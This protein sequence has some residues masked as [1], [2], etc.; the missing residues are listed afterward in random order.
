MARTCSANPPIAQMVGNPKGAVSK[1]GNPDQSKESVLWKNRIAV[2]DFVVPVNQTTPTKVIDSASL[3]DRLETWATPFSSPQKQLDTQPKKEAID[4]SAHLAKLIQQHSKTKDPQM[5]TTSKEPTT[6]KLVEM[7]HTFEPSSSAPRRAPTAQMVPL[8]PNTAVTTA[9]A[10]PVTT[11]TSKSS[12]FGPRPSSMTLSNSKAFFP[13]TASPSLLVAPIIPS[14]STA[15]LKKSAIEKCSPKKPKITMTPAPAIA[16]SASHVQNTKLLSRAKNHTNG[17]KK[18]QRIRTSSPPKSASALESVSEEKRG[19]GRPRTRPEE[20]PLQQNRQHRSPIQP[21]LPFPRTCFSNQSNSS[22][23]APSGFPLQQAQAVTFN[24]NGDSQPIFC[25]EEPRLWPG[26]AYSSLYEPRGPPGSA[27]AS[28][29]RRL[30]DL[31]L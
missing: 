24:I 11:E 26:C 29:T 5:A 8:P 19:R 12:L 1:M 6:P 7:M 21:S 20:Q 28:R 16:P 27:Q 4:A 22:L 18:R 14:S 23:F 10:G 2:N 30:Y 17:V 25:S 31:P 9:P 13:A 3:S 15:A